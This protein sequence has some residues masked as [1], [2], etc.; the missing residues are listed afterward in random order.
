[1]NDIVNTT[2]RPQNKDNKPS[3]LVEVPPLEHLPIIMN[4]NVSMK[5]NFF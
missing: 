4:S 3:L 1:M 2:I 5:N